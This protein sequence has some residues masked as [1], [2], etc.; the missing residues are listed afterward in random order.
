MKIKN[1]SA[2]V[3][4]AGLLFASLVASAQDKKNETAVNDGFMATAQKKAL[5]EKKKVMIV[6]SGLQWCPPCRYFE[7]KVLSAAEFK[8]FA[9]KNFVVMKLDFP[10]N[11]ASVSIEIDGKAYTPKSPESLLAEVKKVSEKYELEAFPYTLL[12]KN[13]GS[14]LFSMVGAAEN[15]KEFIAALKKEMKK[16]NK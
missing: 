9:D 15:A 13:D 7:K 10:S 6:F 4:G 5:A 3:F 14:V 1:M 2:L 11:G 12:L 16:E 8:K